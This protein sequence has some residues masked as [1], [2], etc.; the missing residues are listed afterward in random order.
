[1]PPY[2]A[3]LSA[4]FRTL[5]QYRAAAAA[6]FG[7]QLFWGLIRMMIFE[8]FYRSTT[9]AQPMSYE[10]VVSY[11]WLG[12]ATLVLL[13]W[14]VDREIQAM[15]RS[16]T[17][18]YEMLRP[19]DLYSLW[20]TRAVAWRTAPMLLRCVPMFI[21]AGDATA[22]GAGWVSRGSKGK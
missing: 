13:P 14:N 17:V 9:A 4:R 15:V 11:V 1:M 8:A 18:A 22:G 12:Q 3:I 19:L 2:L 5:L 16:G 6:G 10:E 7:T 21:V 20:F